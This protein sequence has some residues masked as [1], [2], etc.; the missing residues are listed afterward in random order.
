MKKEPIVKIKSMLLVSACVLLTCVT[1]ATSAW[2]L[3]PYFNF[4]N[5]QT[6]VTPGNT[7]GIIT[8]QVGDPNGA[9]A[10][11]ISQV[12]VE[13]PQGDYWV[14]T[15][16][17]DL[18]GSNAYSITLS[19]TVSDTPPA[20]Q[21]AFT[22]TDTQGQSAT[23]YYYLV[24]SNPMLQVDSSTLQAYGAMPTPTL[25]WSDFPS[26]GSGPAYS[27]NYVFEVHIYNMSG[28]LVWASSPTGMTNIVVPSSANLQ[29]NTAYQWSV[30]AMDN[31]QTLASVNNLAATADNSSESS[32]VLLT[33]PSGPGFL[34]ARVYDYKLGAGTTNTVLKCQVAT[35]AG[36]LPGAITSLVVTD[37]GG[38]TVYSFKSSD[39]SSSTYSHTMSGTLSNGMYTFTVKDTNGYQATT[40]H[41]FQSATIPQVDVTT[42]QAS[43]TDSTGPTLTWS[44]PY[45][46]T[47]LFYSV[48]IWDSSNNKVTLTNSQGIADTDFIVPS[49][50]LTNPPYTWAVDVQDMRGPYM[51]NNV[52]RTNQIS[53]S[54]NNNIPNFWQGAA[55][56]NRNDAGAGNPYT[57]M[58]AYFDNP[59]SEGQGLPAGWSIAVTGSSNFSYTYQ[60]ADMQIFPNQA[61]PE[62]TYKDPNTVLSD[63]VYTFTLSYPNGGSGQSQVVTYAPLKNGAQVPM[64][65]SSTI[66][67]TS[68]VS[69][70]ANSPTVSWSAPSGYQGHLYYRLRVRDATNTTVWWSNR[71][72]LTAQTVPSGYTGTGYT[73]DVE[74]DN[75]PSWHIFTNRSDAGWYSL[76]QSENTKPGAPTGVEAAPG[77]AQAAVKF[78]APADGGTP[79]TGYTVTSNPPG[80][81]DSNAGSTSTIHIITGLTQNTP[82]T[83]SVTA[84]NAVNTGPASAA[85][86][87]VTPSATCMSSLAATWELAQFVTGAD[88]P[89][90]ER[91][92]MVI[93]ADGTVSNGSRVASSGGNPSKLPG[94]LWAFPDG[95]W[96]QI[97]QN[98]DTGIV[99]QVESNN[100]VFVCTNTR[101]DGSYSL[102]TGVRQASSCTLAD[103]SGPSNSPYTWALQFLYSEPYPAWLS[104]STRSSIRRETTPVI[105]P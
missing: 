57:D 86:N 30:L 40:H 63:G 46:T 56:Y 105:I 85:S 37:S 72:P 94:A 62:Y 25:T 45:S 92:T 44:A 80:G 101:G 17:D 9:V 18:T 98:P 97:G 81:V 102:V 13:G 67:V 4:C 2:A 27:G 15:P 83:F 39:Y 1:F 91:D 41:Y 21:Y 73:F 3:Y 84:T 6:S 48:N 99:C 70:N 26:G 95:I 34:Y 87:S 55:V 66:Q 71:Q 79:I 33:T 60:P 58:D 76:V 69:G 104:Q 89:W 103:L 35:S 53:L 38:N 29:T 52:S 77:S 23:S 74:A 100:N 11:L 14:M 93:N 88:A 75:D 36:S 90:W 82:Y 31:N 7:G 32:M 10:S 51:A 22:V 19:M 43:G 12:T 59:P 28:N 20:G 49:G 47:P 16:R 8:A 54:L 64:V 42:L 78:T 65:D 68:D 5:V 96:P 61:A 24:N 50:T